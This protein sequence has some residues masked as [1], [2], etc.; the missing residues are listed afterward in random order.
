[1][2]EYNSFS[3]TSLLSQ[4]QLFQQYQ[5]ENCLA[6]KLFNLIANEISI[7]NGKRN[8]KYSYPI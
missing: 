3:E 2:T 1:M 5:F 4:P 7:I 8:R 6:L